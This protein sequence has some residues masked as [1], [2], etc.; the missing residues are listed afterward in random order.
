MALKLDVVLAGLVLWAH[1]AVI[2]FNLF[3]LIAVPLGAWRGWAFVRVFWWRALH[4]AALAVVAL[5]AVFGRACFLTL[6]Q[7][8]L[9]Q[10][11][12][13][14]SSSV[15]L[16]QR[17]VSWAIFWP[18]PVWFFAALYVAIWI[19]AIALWRLVPPRRCGKP[20]R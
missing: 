18:L 2:L 12:G 10:S 5:Q 3:G 15:P 8:A 9:L 1:L 19:Y 13:E 17:W 11:A 16:I 7:S 4:L 14:G 6:W 20:A